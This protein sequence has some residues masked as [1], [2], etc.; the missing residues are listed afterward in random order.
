MRYSEWLGVRIFLFSVS[1]VLSQ[2]CTILNWQ[3]FLA[4][5]QGKE[6]WLTLW[7]WWWWLYRWS[8]CNLYQTD[9]NHADLLLTPWRHVNPILQSCS[10]SKGSLPQIL[11]TGFNAERWDQSQTSVD[12]TAGIEGTHGCELQRDSCCCSHTELSPVKP[13]R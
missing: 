1:V 8:L 3:I 2:S 7:R 9:Y 4:A 12:C 11:L 5:W 13:F 10:C 6:G